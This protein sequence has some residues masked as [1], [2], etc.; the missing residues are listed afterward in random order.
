MT[1][2]L[3]TAFER[4]SRLPPPDQEVYARQILDEL[5]ADERWAELF[6]RTSE[7]QWATMVS[8]AKEDAAEHGTLS[9]DDLKA[10][11]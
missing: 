10:G 2:L 5:A 8:E 4:L 11:L 1:A 3:E 7:T 9:L 6:D